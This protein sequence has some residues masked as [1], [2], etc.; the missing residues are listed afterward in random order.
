[1][2]QRKDGVLRV[3]KDVD[4]PAGLGPCQTCRNRGSHGRCAAGNRQIFLRVIWIG[5]TGGRLC[6]ASGQ[7]RL[8]FRKRK[9]TK[10]FRGWLGFET[11]QP[12]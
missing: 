12:R 4:C 11:V 2:V 8:R 5:P 6:C 9:S 10:A 1:M 7:W 3:I